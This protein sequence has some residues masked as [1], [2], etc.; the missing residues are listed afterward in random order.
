MGLEIGSETWHS[1]FCK[2]VLWICVGFVQSMV[3]D[4]D[5]NDTEGFNYVLK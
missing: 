5:K 4:E 3:D 2:T 1:A